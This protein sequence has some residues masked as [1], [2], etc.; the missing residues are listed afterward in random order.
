MLWLQKCGL[1][2]IRIERGKRGE[3]ELCNY[4]NNRVPGLLR[5][6]WKVKTEDTYIGPRWEI[7]ETF[8]LDN[9]RLFSKV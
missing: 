1:A 7:N 8:H 4:Y 3:L 5:G 9:L 2:E 6:D